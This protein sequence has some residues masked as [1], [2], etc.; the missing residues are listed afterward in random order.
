MP[1]PVLTLLPLCLAI[2]SAV[3]A[4]GETPAPPVS[5]EFCASPETLPVFKTDLPEGVDRDTASSDITADSLELVKDQTTIFSGA[6]EVQRG[7]QWLATDQVTFEHDSERFIT[8]G[9][10]RYQD[11]A[12][13]LTASQAKADQRSNRIELTDI[14]YQL[15]AQNGNGVAATA[16]MQDD[17]GKLTQATYSTCPPG[18]RQW[19]FSASTI[20]IDQKRAMGSAYNAKLK[21][22]GVPILWLPYV[23]FPTDDRRRTGLLMPTLGYDQTNGLDLTL[24]VYLNL[25]PNYDAT[26]KPRLLS[27]R[28]LLMGSELRYL[29]ARHNGTIEGYWLPGDDIANRDRHYLK[30]DHT[31]RLTGNWYASAHLNDVS[32]VRYF[33]DFGE[34]T[35]LNAITLLNSNAGFYGRGKGWTASLS[36]ERWQIASPLLPSGSE[37][38]RRL[39]RARFDWERP[40][41]GMLEGGISTEAVRF[42]HATLEG[43]NRFDLRPYLRAPLGG[44][45]WF[46]TPEL[47]WRYTGYSLDD[48]LVGANG[49]DTPSRSVPIASLDAGLVFERDFQWGQTDLLQ[50]LEPR[51]FYLRV[52]TRNQD[53]LPLLDTQAL[54][55][56][57]P[58]LFRDNRFGGADRQSDANQITAAL[59][60]RVFSRADGRELLSASLG[61]V[62]YFDPPEVKLP[63]EPEPPSGG[64]AYVAEASLAVSDR[65]DIDF[66]QQWQPSENRT[67]L[68]A[69]RSQ[70]RY[71][72]GGLLN[73]AYRYRVGVLEQTDLS[74][75]VPIN[76]QWR[77]IGRW[78]Y[79]LRDGQTIE[80]MG[81]FEW[82]SC[83]VALRL[84]ARRYTRI[85]DA[86]QN[87]GIFL[88]LELNGVGSLGRDTAPL[89]D[90][91]ILGYSR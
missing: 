4:A 90:N 15:E 29:T 57:W 71:G 72:N 77:L 39:P 78:N 37:P 86:S 74:F 22:G 50:T 3:H 27:D 58:G 51:L 1:R 18:Q 25:A 2:S 13:R 67:S 33:R 23:Q 46:L 9:P 45:Y 17:R 83:C 91:G 5:W 28:G 70:W 80:S 19:E 85:F 60:S 52:P 26:L 6:V 34:T 62:F 8:E 54:S 53:D 82:K 38:Y 21:V 35:S 47:A 10:V 69:I 87:L 89:L 12:V 48:G 41:L 55:F 84:V 56:S 42:E 24:P 44:S 73:A 76:P 75:V 68:S 66:A 7:D 63:G 20:K 81:G 49:N 11:H 88:E 14:R 65:W 40:L 64:S 59:S 36:A 31:S 16:V 30:L 61:R 43:A 32:D 79:S